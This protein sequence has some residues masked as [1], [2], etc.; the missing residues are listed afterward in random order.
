ML[1]SGGVRP[2]Y[3]SL[4]NSK[5]SLFAKAFID[6][7]N[8]NEGILEGYDLYTNVQSK[9]SAEARTFNVEQDPLYAPIKHAGHEAGEFFF[10]PQ[11]STASLMPLHPSPATLIGEQ[12]FD[13][14]DLNQEGELQQ[15][16]SLIR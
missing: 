2:V 1:S 6:E 9:V 11:N 3:D 14:F 16:A 15:I 5:H 8:Q 13:A 4:G 7:L 12:S 10:L